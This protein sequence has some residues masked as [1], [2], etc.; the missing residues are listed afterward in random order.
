MAECPTPVLLL[1]SLTSEGADVTLRG[2][3]LGAMDFVDKSS[4][5]G[6]MNLLSLAEELKAKVRALASVPRAR[7]RR[8]RRPCATSCRCPRRTGA[9]R[10]GRHR[11][12][13][14]RAARAAGHHPA[15]CRRTFAARCWS[16]STCRSGSPGLWPSGSTR[17][18]SCSARGA[19]T[20][21][22]RAAGRVL[23]APAGRHMKVRR[24]RASPG[25][26]AGRRAQDAAPPLGRRAHAVGGQAYGGA[27]AGR[28]PDRHGR[29]RRRGPARHPRGRRPHPGRERGDAASSTG[30]PRRPWR[31][32]SSI[33]RCP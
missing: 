31:R 15:R 29:G 2:L 20:D 26:L 7:L 23:I 9:G 22:P 1:S 21:E 12:L 33:A 11:H 27:G 17:A 3:E 24:R 8:G 28:G 4:V 13:H 19:R 32:G 16:C 10:R 5:Q 6:H 18:A 30:C 25:C 14:G